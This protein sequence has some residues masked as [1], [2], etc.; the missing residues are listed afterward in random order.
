MYTY[1]CIYFFVNKCTQFL[2]CR[3]FLFSLKIAYIIDYT[4]YYRARFMP[5]KFHQITISRIKTFQEKSK[6][7]L[8][9]FVYW[10]F[11]FRCRNKKL[12]IRLTSIFILVKERLSDF[13]RVFIIMILVSQLF[14]KF[15]AFSMVIGI[16]IR[17]NILVGIFIEIKS[18]LCHIVR[19]QI[20]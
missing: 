6:N 12:I 17:I 3:S 7:I 15:S 8:Y 20:F 13:L 19:M 1:I 11:I 10:N 9:D 16:Y 18:F 14:I 4:I 2:Y 5:S